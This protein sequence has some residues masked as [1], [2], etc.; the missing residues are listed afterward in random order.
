[1]DEDKSVPATEKGALAMRLYDLA[2]K[3]Y[4]AKS[5]VLSVE[6]IALIERRVPQIGFGPIVVAQ[7][8]R[9]LDP[10]LKK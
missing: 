8:L 7:A 5:V 2:H 4:K 1:L 3:I 9:M 10:A 6:E